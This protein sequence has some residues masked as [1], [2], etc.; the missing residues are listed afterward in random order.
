MNNKKIVILMITLLLVLGS[1]SAA[2]AWGTHNSLA[3]VDPNYNGTYNATTHHGV[4]EYTFVIT[5]VGDGF[6]GV[7]MVSL[8]FDKDVFQTWSVVS[9]LPA[10]WNFTAYDGG[11]AMD[12]I[13]SLGTAGTKLLA[14]GDYLKVRVEY[15]LF[16]APL[17]LDWSEGGMHPNRP[18][19]QGFSTIATDT[20]AF[21]QPGGSTEAVPEPTTALLFG[22]GIALI[23]YLRKKM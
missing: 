13:F 19:S 6:T 1:T 20:P 5:G 17:N 2:M 10:D 8:K 3:Y 23:G 11:P 18:W 12:V 16:D 7:D 21:L 9:S 15:T 22:S 14:I 4:A